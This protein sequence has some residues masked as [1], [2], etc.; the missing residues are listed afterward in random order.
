[1]PNVVFIH[2]H[3]AV[4]EIESSVAQLSSQCVV[5]AAIPD[6]QVG[7]TTHQ[8]TAVGE[9]PAERAAA[10]IDECE[11]HADILA[12]SDADQRQW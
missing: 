4:A 6:H 3:S 8:F 10:V 1:M 5:T 11:S 9:M 12:C 2:Q 7:K